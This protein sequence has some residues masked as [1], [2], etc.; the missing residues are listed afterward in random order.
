MSPGRWSA[1][2]DEHCGL[3]GPDCCWGTGILSCGMCRPVAATG[4]VVGLDKE[5]SICFMRG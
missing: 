4:P 5:H 2:K 1:S 3:G